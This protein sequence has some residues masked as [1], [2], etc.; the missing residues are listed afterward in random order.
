MARRAPRPS[1]PARA[2]APA[3]EIQAQELAGIFAV[4]QWL[5]DLGLA[6]WLLVG[7]TALL[8]AV[9]GILSLTHSIDL[10]QRRRVPRGLGAAIV[11]LLVVAVSVGVALLILTGIVSEAEGLRADLK[12]AAGTLGG[13]LE[14]AGVSASGAAQAESGSSD[15]VSSAFRVLLSGLSTGIGALASLAVFLSFTAISLFFLLKDGPV[16]RDWAERHMGVPHSVARAITGRVLQSLRG[17][18]A[19]VTAVAVFNAVV[20]GL[21]ALVLGVPRAGS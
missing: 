10:P 5:R 17:Y 12:D 4:P 9:V 2:P 18:F 7:V 6:A 8:V 1:R 21:G 3:D 15:A 19:G 20:V 14:D 16:I 11:L 13:W